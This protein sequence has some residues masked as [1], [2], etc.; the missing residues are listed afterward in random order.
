M[1]KL[2]QPWKELICLPTILS[3]FIFVLNLI[4]I[5]NLFRVYASIM[6]QHPHRNCFTEGHSFQEAII[7]IYRVKC[8]F[9]ACILLTTEQRH[10]A[11]SGSD[12]IVF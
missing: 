6:T 7:S 2:T 10:V 9:P 3:M 12:F 5:F 8:S 1:F 4:V 11:M